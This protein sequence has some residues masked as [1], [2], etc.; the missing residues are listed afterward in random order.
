M[1]APW[2][3][4]SPRYLVVRLYSSRSSAWFSCAGALEEQ[5]AL[6]EVARERRRPLELRARLVETAEPGEEVAAHARQEVVALERRLRGQRIDELE[7]RRRPERHRERDRPIQLHDGRRRNLGER[8]VERRDRCP[9]RLLRSARLR[10][11]GGDRGLE[12]VRTKRTTESRCAL[13]CRETATDQELVPPRAVLI[14]QQDRLSRGPDPGAQARRLELHQRDEAVDLG[15]LRNELSQD[16][17]ETQRLLAERRSNPVVTGGR[18]VA[19][20]EDQVDDLEHRRQTGGEFGPARDLE[21]DARLAKGPL[22]PHDALGDG[23]LRDEERARDLRG[24]QPPEQAERERN[25]RLGREHRMAGYED[26]AEEVVPHVVEGRVE[27]HHGPLLLGLELATE[28]LVLALR[29][30]DPAQPV[31]RAMS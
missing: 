22:R 29:Q 16:A 27:I 18:R 4:P 28:F 10:V 23:R 17:A 24:L 13:K 1:H 5:F 21:R 2:L 15:L 8:I 6:A 9:V 14:E 26:E 25:A 19:L 20:V 30:L 7:A 11:T 31:D 12:R 3:G